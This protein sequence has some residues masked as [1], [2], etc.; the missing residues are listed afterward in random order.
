MEQQYEE[1]LDE[2]NFKLTTFPINYKNIWRK[3]KDMVACFWTAEEVDFSSDYEDFMTLNNNEQHFI[4]RILA[5]FA[6]SD[7]I[8]NLNL[9]ERFTSEIK[10]TEV[11]Y[12]YQ[13]QIMMENVHAEVY[14]LMLDNIVRDVNER[15]MLFNAIKVI[16]SIKLLSDWAI[17][18]IESDKHIGFRLVAFIILEGI[19][20]SG[21]FA[22]I[23]WLKKYKTI[24][25]LK[26]DSTARPFMYG[27]TTSNKWISRD[28]KLH[29]EYG[30]EVYGLLANKLSTDEIF[31]MFD[32]AINISKTFMNDAI[33]IHLIGMNQDMMNDYIEYIADRALVMLGYPKKYLKHNPFKFMEEIGLNDK[34]NF[35]ELTPTE[36]QNSHTNNL[37]TNIHEVD[38]DD[39]ENADF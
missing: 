38:M 31:E 24:N 6:A 22:S 27:L 8:V 36:Y 29:Y 13:F 10:I 35:H 5:F 33:P 26:S 25:K 16:P 9:A 12:G 28:E 17:R 37:T 2:N 7:G 34:T 21:A 39:V 30:C 4:K 1:I 3:Y 11:L 20:F 19:F 14:S 18:W 32:E 15:M 23:F